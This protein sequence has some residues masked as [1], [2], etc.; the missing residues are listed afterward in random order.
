MKCHFLFFVILSLASLPVS[1]ERYWSVSEEAKSI[2]AKNCVKTPDIASM[3]N[4]IRNILAK[5]Q[6]FKTPTWSD[7]FFALFGRKFIGAVVKEVSLDGLKLHQINTYDFDVISR[8]TMYRDANK[9]FWRSEYPVIETEVGGTTVIER[10]CLLKNCEKN[11]IKLN[12]FNS[13]PPC[14]D[15]F[16]AAMKIFDTKKGTYILWTYLKY[17]E[18]LSP[19][20][21]V[22]ADPGGFDEATMKDIIAAFDGAPY[23]IK[24]D[25]LKDNGFFRFSK[26]YTLAINGKDKVIANAAGAVF[27]PIDNYDDAQKIEIFIH[28]IGH[29]VS[30]QLNQADRSKEWAEA[31][32]WNFQGFFSSSNSN[33]SGWVSEY[34]KENTAEDFAETFSAYRLDPNYLKKVSPERYEYMKK[35]VFNGVEFIKDVCKGRLEVSSSA[36]NKQIQ[37]TKTQ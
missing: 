2:F 6:N 16:C 12:I 35:H 21:D 30:Y 36:K 33:T 18:N 23:Q 9:D 4:E 15:A 26:G 8:L 31:S 3:Q 28:E 20:S 32:G 17:G 19:Y 7:R 29:R 34:A 14:S 1:A 10:Q 24:N 37:P 11:P 25:V 5:N 27:D 13:K 22:N